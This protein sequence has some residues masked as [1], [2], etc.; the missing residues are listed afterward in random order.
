MTVIYYLLV[1]YRTSLEQDQALP[2][3]VPTTTSEMIIS[4]HEDKNE[5]ISTSDEELQSLIT[6][7]TAHLLPEL[8]VTFEEETED[9]QSFMSETKSSEEPISQEDQI[10]DSLALKSIEEPSSQSDEQNS[11]SP[12]QTTDLTK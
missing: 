10:P 5:S 2:I 7:L 9:E 3:P 11:S 1:L 6:S 12:T 8:P 4:M